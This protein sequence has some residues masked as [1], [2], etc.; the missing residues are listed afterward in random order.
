MGLIV[1]GISSVTRNPGNGWITLLAALGLYAPFALGQACAGWNEAVHIGELARPIDEASGLAASRRFPGR[2][3]HINDSGDTGRFFITGM[4]GGNT[5]EVGID[6]FAPLD[7]EALGLGPCG[8]GRSC[9]FV[10]DIGD[11]ERK[12]TAIEIV[13]IDELETF[14][15]SVTPRRRIRLR[16][17]DGAHDAE[18]MAV[19]PN[20]AIFILTKEQPA[21]LFKVSGQTLVQVMTLDVNRPTDMA[22]AD[23]GKRLLV[24]TYRDAIEFGIDFQNFQAPTYRQEVPIQ[25]L[26]QEESIAYLPGSRSFVY[27]T[28]KVFLLAAWI[29]RMDCAR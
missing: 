16:Y 10:A 25:P 7:T 27:T 22:I 5:R 11:N 13:L 6:G 24:L 19:H 15:A 18:S 29:M 12:R 9:L 3:Y 17:P 20:G 8:G 4:N 14:D 28:E 26:Q 21:K 1:F 2:L 23:D